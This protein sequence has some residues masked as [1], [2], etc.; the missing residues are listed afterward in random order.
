M[1]KSSQTASGAVQNDSIPN[2][3]FTLLL[4]IENLQSI[5]F[6]KTISIKERHM[7]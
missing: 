3:E 5:Q 7:Q 4:Q 2:L 6:K 1:K